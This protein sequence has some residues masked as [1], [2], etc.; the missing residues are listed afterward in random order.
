M[1]TLQNLRT[2]GTWIYLGICVTLVVALATMG[3]LVA[4]RVDLST[5][6]EVAL[7]INIAATV[8]ALAGLYYLRRHMAFH[9]GRAE[10]IEEERRRH[11]RIDDLTGALN[12]RSFMEEL[13]RRVGTFR[14][15]RSAIL[16]VMDVDEF[17]Q[18]N[19][20]F[21][22][23]VGDMALATIVDNARTIF[24]EGIIG[25]LGG[26]EFAVLFEGDDVERCMRSA[27]TLLGS[28]QRPHR[29]GK[30]E[31][32]LSVSIGVA[33]VPRHTTLFR[34]LTVL[35][36]LALYQS[37]A[38]GRGRATL[39]DPDMLSEERQKSFMERELRAAI[40]LNQLELHY[41][42][43]VNP[44]GTVFALEALVRWNHD[45]RGQ[46]LPGEFIP[47]AE[48]SMLIDSLG[49]WV[50]R[51]ACLDLDEF[52]GCL[53]SVNVSAAQLQRDA[54]VNMVCR[55][56]KETRR[57]AD[58]FVIEITET[59]ATS[60]A[61]EVL[62]RLEALRN[63]GFRIALDDFGTGHCGFNYLKTLPID[64]VK[65]DRSYIRSL[66]SDEVA[67]IFVA[68]LTQIGR[69]LGLDIVAEGVETEEERV[70]AGASG[71]DRFQGYLI[72]R[73]LTKAA[74]VRR[75]ASAFAAE[76]ADVTAERPPHPLAATAAA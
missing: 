30:G 19:D 71:C 52:G 69:A 33:A 74:L 15:G 18:L 43:I 41:Q 75:Y 63:M 11:M 62:R 27:E 57:S 44:D 21:G 13:R 5:T 51:R 40:M 59:V 2:Y 38:D 64:S 17:K 4:T 36:D 60:A 12:R 10:A 26:D 28:L 58:R 37:K 73:P 35:A 7:R 32:A 49:E 68:A 34:E 1:S 25:R 31:I 42:P 67:Q 3:Y 14:D 9:L 56:L 54:F 24:S 20:S 47:I 22:H 48:R 23:H 55:V 70:L 66:G 29:L 8:V 46:I 65:I 61:P 76:T 50:F 45:Y 16:L 6:M 39:F 53:I 72:S